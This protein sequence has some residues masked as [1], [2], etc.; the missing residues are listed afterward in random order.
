VS[1]KVEDTRFS[2][3]FLYLIIRDHL[4]PG[5]VLG[6]V[7]ELEKGNHDGYVFSNEHLARLA[8]SISDRLKIP[9]EEASP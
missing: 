1:G 2:T 6:L 5:T 8:Q 3:A 4:Q 7:D 9:P